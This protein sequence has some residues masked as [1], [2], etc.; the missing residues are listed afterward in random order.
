METRTDISFGEWLKRRRRALGLT[1]EQLAAQLNCSTILL[2]KIE[3]E[4]RRPSKLLTEQLAAILQ[5]PSNEQAKFKEYARGKLSSVIKESVE[6][7]PWQ[8]NAAA[9]LSNLP[10]SATSFIGRIED[11]AHLVEYASDENIRLITLIGPPGIGKSRLGLQVARQMLSAFPDGVFFVPLAPLVRPSQVAPAIF[12]ALGFAES[13]NQ[14]SVE[15]LAKSIGDKQLLILLDNLEHLI[16]DAAALTTKLLTACP[17]LKVLATSRESLRVPGE[18][19]YSVAPLDF[20]RDAAP[21]DIQALA[22]FPALALFTERARAVSAGF[23]ATTET[24]QTIASIC[25]RLDGVPLAIELIASRI[26]FH[27]PQALLRQMDDP[28][29]LSADGMRGVP[30][31]QKTLRNAIQWSYDLLSTDE[32]ELLKRIS[33]FSGGLTPD[34][35][36]WIFTNGAAEKPTAPLIASLTDKS[37]IQRTLDDD[38]P[39]LNMLMMI[40]EFALQELRKSGNESNTRD[41]H[42]AYFLELAEKADRAIH[43][44]DQISWMSQIESEHNNFQTALDWCITNGYTE[45]ALRLLGALG[46]TWWIRGHYSEYRSWFV[47][48]SALPGAADFAASYAKV[49]NR[50]GCQNWN[51]AQERDAQAFLE[52][53][54][55]IWLSL[56]TEGEEGLA[57]CLNWQSFAVFDGDVDIV[58]AGAL[59]QS[60]LALYQKHGATWGQAHAMLTAGYVRLSSADDISPLARFEQSLELFQQVGD[61]WGSSQA[62]QCIGRVH[63][64]RGELDQARACFEQQISMDQ[65]VGY[66]SGI[67]NGLCDFGH[68]HFLA[69]DAGRAEEY[70]V[71]SLAFCRQHGM[72]PDRSPLFYTCLTALYQHDY[73]T[74]A[75]RFLKLYAITEDNTKKR[76]ILDLVSGIAAVA[77]GT[78]QPERAATLH[79]AAD[80]ILAETGFQY[81]PFFRAVLDG[82]IQLAREQLGQA[83]FES[84]VLQGR[85]MNTETAVGYA[86]ETQI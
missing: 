82:P 84:L 28:F 27:S 68:V 23:S 55:L 9:P 17:H 15:Q 40:R 7:Y 63:L 78:E 31:R 11:L 72:D 37:L 79:G 50:M 29:I 44:P 66:I 39:R 1:Q 61:I 60:S 33:V 19:L 80:K 8:A 71:Q 53:A 26:R 30:M 14:F 2:R 81:P 20:P 34:A 59:I 5:V 51:L 49:L 54:Q 62:Y 76:D 77:G 69:G 75:K 65:S 25:A 47:Q 12:Q 21:L 48:V 74:A 35:A 57:D 22:A 6:R 43:G 32:Q 18:W 52:Q 13:S 70:Y 38:M 58:K 45:S 85:L 64:D 73:E 86:L 4:E 56:G 83:T 67:I 10:A 41:Q 3:A 24:I 36:D 16:E 46:W 42:L